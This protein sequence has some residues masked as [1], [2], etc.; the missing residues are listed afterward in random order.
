VRVWLPAPGP[1]DEDRSLLVDRRFA[2]SAER[3]TAEA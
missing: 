3:S 2:G 1:A